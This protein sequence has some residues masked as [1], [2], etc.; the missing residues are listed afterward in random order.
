MSLDTPERKAAFA[1][2]TGEMGTD[3]VT[4]KP[5][6]VLAARLAD[7]PDLTLWVENELTENDNVLNSL[8]ATVDGETFA[9]F[10]APAGAE[11]GVTELTAVIP[12]DFN[13]SPDVLNGVAELYLD[14]DLWY[15]KVV[16]YTV[17]STVGVPKEDMKPALT[18]APGGEGEEKTYGPGAAVPT[19][20]IQKGET[21]SLSFQLSGS[22]YTWGD[23]TKVTYFEQDGT[24][25]DPTAHFAWRSSDLTV[26]R[27][28]VAEDGAAAVIPTGMGGT[29][30]FTLAAL[31]GALPD[32][33]TEA[34]N[35]P[36][37]VGQEPFLM[38]PASG[39]TVPIREG[40]DA[41]V[42]WS[43]NLCQKNETAGEAGPS[44]PPPSTC[45][46]PAER[47]PLRTLCGR[48]I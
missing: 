13:T 28:S 33:E 25:A 16:D 8:K 43:S 40:Q 42:N 48:P 31:N 39:K 21:L 4:G 17:E 38:I 44:S 20:F 34:I 9:P 26:A 22:G 35:V 29:V 6:L 47:A 5:R 7:D 32:A 19:V 37:A 15:G 30:S 41:V 1:S 18:V 46:F 24:L 27:I 45:P 36:F 2:I 11:G 10:S 14:G 3:P 12:L 23:T